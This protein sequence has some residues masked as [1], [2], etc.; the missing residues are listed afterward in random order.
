MPG[1]DRSK[2][3]GLARIA[4]TAHGNGLFAD[5]VPSGSYF[6]TLIRTRILAGG[7]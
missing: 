3:C 6:K 1:R 2:A 5:P 4:A 7:E